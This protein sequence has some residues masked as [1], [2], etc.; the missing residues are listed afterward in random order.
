MNILKTQF[1]QII[2]FNGTELTREIGN[3]IVMSMVMLG[4]L[5]GSKILPIPKKYF[6]SELKSQL[7]PKIVD[8]N[9]RAFEIGYKKVKEY[10]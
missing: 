6:R 4:A 9:L 8:I 5:A 10:I 2:A 1:N 7:N 3:P